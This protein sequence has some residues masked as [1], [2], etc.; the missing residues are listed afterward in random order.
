MDDLTKDLWQGV[1]GRG[2]HQSLQIGSPSP[3]PVVELPPPVE[4]GW[5]AVLQSRLVLVYASACAL[6]LLAVIAI[7]TAYPFGSPGVS[8][9]VSERLHQPATCT[10]R[11]SAVVAGTRQTL[12]TCDVWTHKSVRCFAVSDGQIRQVFERRELGC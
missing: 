5:R 3:A 6:G 4:T 2:H 12:Y 7:I 8:E 11:G 10:A 9:R 1:P